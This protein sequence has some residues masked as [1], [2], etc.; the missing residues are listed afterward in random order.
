MSTEDDTKRPQFELREGGE[1]HFNK[2]GKSTLLAKFDEERGRLTF[3]SFSIDQ[4]YRSQILRAVTED[5]LTGEQTGRVVKGYAIAGRPRDVI[6]KNEPP[7]PRKNA[8]LGDKTPEFVKW[9]FK[10]RPQAAYAR[11]G[12]L[13]D[14]NDEP[15]TAHC[16]RMERGLLIPN[17]S[18]KALEIGKEGY[19]VLGIT[20]IDKEDGILATRATCMT[21]LVNEIVKGEGDEAEKF[22]PDDDMEP[23]DDEGGEEEKP[24]K[25]GKKSKKSDEDDDSAPGSDEA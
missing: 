4:Q 14:S 19:E 25:G 2:K 20:T 6:K 22:A 24:A 5:W 1:I 8:M 15:K 13:L 10:W 3:E 9:L 17:E 7:Q 11:Y 12:V 18:G 16:F 21:F 23:V